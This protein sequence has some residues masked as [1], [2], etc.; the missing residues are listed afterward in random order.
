MA[1]APMSDALR[2]ETLA[3]LKKANGNLTLASQMANVPRTTFQSRVR[4]AKLSMPAET[5]HE[6]STTVELKDEIRTLKAQIASFNRETLDAKYIREKIIK[7]AEQPV[8]V[9]TW[10]L[11][12]KAPKSA[13]GVPTLLASDWHWGE[14]VDPAQIGGVNEY[15]LKTAHDRAKRMINNTVDLL[16]NHMVN[17][18]YPGIVFALGGDMI[19]GDIHEELVATNEREVMPTVVDLWGVLA[20]CIETLAD[21]FGRVFVPCVGGNHGRN[22]YDAETEI[23]TSRGWLKIDAID[24]DNDEI[25][26]YVPESDT[27]RFEKSDGWFYDP[28]YRGDM[29]SVESKGVSLL[30]TPEHTLWVK[31]PSAKHDLKSGPKAYEYPFSER[32]ASERKWGDVWAAQC[33]INGWVGDAPAITVPATE[34]TD[35]MIIEPNEKW[36]EFFGWYVSEGCSDDSRITI[37]QSA[38]MNPEK[39]ARVA[40]LL[41]ELGFEPKLRWNMIRIGCSGLARFLNSEFG[42]GAKN[43]RLPAW[44]K[45]WPK[46]LLAAFFDAAMDGDGCWEK[47]GGSSGGYTSASDELLDGMQEVA[48]KIGYST[49][50]GER[51]TSPVGDSGY[52]GTARKLGVTKT[53]YRSMSESRVI[54]YNG[55]I[56][57][58]R[59]STGLVVVRRNGKAVISGNTKKMRA[60]GRNFT[61]FDWLLY[62]FLAKRFEGDA[63]VTFY[64]PDGADAL[65]SV[66]GHRYLLTHGDQFRGGDALIGPL[67]PIVRGDHRKRARNMQI[68]ADYDTIV[69]GHWHQLMQ[70][71]KFIVNGSLIGYNEYAYNNNYG[72]EPPRQALW[73]THPERGITFHMPVQVDGKKSVTDQPWIQWGKV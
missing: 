5:P 37:S 12:N 14:V 46:N 18:S 60:K 6:V 7:L 57:C 70:T 15:S 17:P 28:A 4:T 39:Y 26:A 36:A 62:T 32:K 41:A 33:A 8:R 64:I 25:A 13:P 45:N 63:R 71:Q 40:L 67:G 9:P 44:L 54:Q 69:M 24:Q 66:Y 21:K 58:P 23:L 68:N 49:S 65:Y 35:E 31:A 47:R 61:S 3:L 20:W 22:C 29:I 50:L 51:Y 16:N 2:A 11:N 56:W 73:I 43:K 52:C 59:V 19:T 27:I 30:V 38:E 48:F 55:P 10:L 42:K 1:N 34:R 53:P 72:F